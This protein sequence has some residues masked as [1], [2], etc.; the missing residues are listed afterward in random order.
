MKAIPFEKL[1]EVPIDDMKMKCNSFIQ[2]KLGLNVY[3][4][5]LLIY[6]PT[7]SIA[8]DYYV[9]RN[10]FELKD[11]F[12]KYTR[13][14]PDEKFHEFPSR[15][16]FTKNQEETRMKYFHI[17]LN[18]VLEGAK[19]EN[20]AEDKLN[21]LYNFLF[22]HKDTINIKLTK[23]MIKETFNKDVADSDIVDIEK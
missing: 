10:Y 12:D 3:R 2:K 20:K 4:V 16:T 7:E 11:L 18:K 8:R 23:E 21:L 9:H 17:F 19:D 15:L 6:S 1:L 14:Y 5:E 13:K 22:E